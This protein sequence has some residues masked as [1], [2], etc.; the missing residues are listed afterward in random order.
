MVVV[1]LE[2]IGGIARHGN[3]LEDNGCTTF[4]R[5]GPLDSIDLSSPA[6]HFNKTGECVCF[7]KNFTIPFTMAIVLVQSFLMQFQ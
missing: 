6:P 4:I 7:P 3:N 1:S 2:V 5:V